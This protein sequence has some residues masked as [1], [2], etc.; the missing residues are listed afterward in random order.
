MPLP[1]KQSKKRLWQP[2]LSEK[3][4]ARIE[5]LPFKN[6]ILASV[7]INLTTAILVI[8]LQKFLPPEVPLFYGLPKGEEQ[9]ANSVRL[10]IPSLVSFIII[11]FN[12]ALSLF[13]DDDFSK[14][15]LILAGA[16]VV[17]LTTI[18]TLKIILLVGSF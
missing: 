3:N 17:F 9:L 15:A 1:Q 2:G 12:S 5:K 7:V 16:S 13:L 8:L 18:T 6:L 11:S 4:R 10:I 14:K